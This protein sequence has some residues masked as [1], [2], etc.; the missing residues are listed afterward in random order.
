MEGVRGINY[1]GDIA[2]DDVSFTSDA[3][4]SKYKTTYPCTIFSHV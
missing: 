4:T 1:K 2:I 3:C